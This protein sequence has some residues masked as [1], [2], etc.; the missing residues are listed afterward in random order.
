M[1]VIAK[2]YAEALFELA[3]E[4]GLLD[5]VEQ[6]IELVATGIRDNP[7]F[8]DFLAHPRIADQE[9][10]QALHNVFGKHIS[11]VTSHLLQL[12]V[13]KGRLGLLSELVEAYIAMANE[14]RGV[15]IGTAV[16]TINLDEAEK[17]R[18]ESSFTSAVGSRVQ[19]R[20]KVNPEIQGGIVVRIGDR[21]FDGS[22]A[23]KLARFQNQ[24]QHTQ[25]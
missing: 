17:T 7:S 5:S 18:L 4:R 16:T 9:K 12:L 24:L 1:S 8:S 14:S 3:R 2:R 13:D 11:D 22:I 20:N 23:S 25:V 6:D 19:L 15:S 10:K 21:V